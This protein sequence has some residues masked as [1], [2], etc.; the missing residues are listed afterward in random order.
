MTEIRV[1]ATPLQVGAARTTER[2]RPMQ[3]T[4]I[5]GVAL[6]LLVVTGTAGAMPGAAGAQADDTTGDDSV[7]TARGPA[8]NGSDAADR[9]PATEPADRG[10]P[11]D[12]PDQVP[13]FVGDIHQLV[14]QHTDGDHDGSLGDQI[15]DLTPGDEDGEESGADAESDGADTADTDAAAGDEDTTPTAQSDA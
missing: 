10:P 14:Q 3:L 9:D 7:D 11:A 4:R 13:D 15:R 6:A 12:L 1:T 8:T 2:T 5:A